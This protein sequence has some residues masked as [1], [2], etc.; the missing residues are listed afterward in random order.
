MSIDDVFKK[1]MRATGFIEVIKDAG[2]LL[3]KDR[4]WFYRKRSDFIDY[5]MFQPI[6]SGK[7][8]RIGVSVLKFDMFPEYDYSS[9]P[10]GFSNH[11]RNISNKYVSKRG[12]SFAIGDWD[13]SG[14]GRF[15]RTF[16]ELSGLLE[17][18]IIPWFDAIDTNKKLYDSIF[19]DYKD[20]GSYD[21]LLEL[22]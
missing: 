14:V 6:A 8:V 3:A 17:D 19:E 15:E 10:S 13:T 4:V 12:I 20:D 11:A 9:F 2:F 7:G 18:K 22:D 1:N 5:F 16:K 21:Y